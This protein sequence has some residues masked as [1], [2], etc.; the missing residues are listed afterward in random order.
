MADSPSILRTAH[1]AADAGGALLVAETPVLD[2][3]HPLDASHTAAALALRRVRGR[4]FTKGNVAAADR[5]P[6]L[7]RIASDPHTPE[8]QRRVRRKA[9]SLEGA[10]R[11]E[12]SVQHGA[13]V[14]TGCR[15][16]LVAWA[17]ATAWSS[18][19]YRAGDAT[20]GAA[21]A[22]KASGHQLKAIAIA[23]REAASRRPAAHD[24]PWFVEGPDEPE[25]S[26][27]D[28]EDPEPSEDAAP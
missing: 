3:M 23:E 9:A 8:E 19:Y 6:S 18:A 15:V 16:E 22:E 11:R 4:P 14:S 12:L 26:T 28:D 13:S 7:T 24:T 27:E 20:K 5:G 2:E 25:P 21:L 17:L 10:R 1:G